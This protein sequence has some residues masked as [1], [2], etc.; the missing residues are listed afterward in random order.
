MFSNAQK[1]AAVLNKWAQPAIQGLLGSRLGQLPFMANIDAKLRSTGWV[2]PMWSLSKEISPLI[3][4]L[5]SSLV[6]PMLAKYL[7]GIPDDS[8]PELAHKI[9]EDAIKNGGLSLFEG[10]VE[11]EPEDLE[12]LKTLL[13]YNLPVEE[14]TNT[15]KV[16]TEEP[17]PQGDDVEK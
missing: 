15:Y 7:Q 14:K 16:L 12:E 3:D 13:R 10:K 5:S 2:S 9:V 1:L 6:E 8:I 11:F 4:G 17:T